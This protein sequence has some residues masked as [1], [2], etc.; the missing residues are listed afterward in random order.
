MSLD[1]AFYDTTA[2]LTRLLPILVE[3]T[4]AQGKHCVIYVENSDECTKWNTQLWTYSTLS[5]LPHASDLQH[6][7]EEEIAAQPIFITMQDTDLN[8]AAI[9]F[10]LRKQYPVLSDTIEK[11]IEFPV[12]FANLSDTSLPK[13]EAALIAQERYLE[14]QDHYPL[15]KGVLR[16]QESDNTWREILLS[17]ETAKAA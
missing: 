6:L 9:I 12:C 16:S 14:Y 10:N 17:K 2:P 7:T 11:V 4:Y 15:I 3:K 1:L 5:F 13:E 8:H